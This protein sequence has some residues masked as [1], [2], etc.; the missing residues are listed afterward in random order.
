M[1]L[2]WIRLRKTRLHIDT[3]RAP[4]V[5][6]ALFASS[7][8]CIEIANLA[9]S[10][11]KRSN[12]INFHRCMRLRFIWSEMMDTKSLLTLSPYKAFWYINWCWIELNCL[13]FVLLALLVCWRDSALTAWVL[14]HC[15]P[16]NPFQFKSNFSSC[17]WG[18]ARRSKWFSLSF[19]QISDFLS[20]NVH[21]IE[22][23]FQSSPRKQNL[24]FCSLYTL[25]I[26]NF[27]YRIEI[28]LFLSIFSE[29]SFQFF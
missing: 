15:I 11:A 28:D 6:H 13:N 1:Y 18:G 20:K 26:A 29:N 16:I 12:I 24:A 8:A 23:H 19:E 5:I 3:V 9:D 27:L 25:F 21:I 14:T 2:R 7:L 10:Y 17:E 22:R 4:Y